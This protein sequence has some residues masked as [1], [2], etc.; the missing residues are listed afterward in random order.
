M[1][2]NGELTD[3]LCDSENRGLTL[4]RLILGQSIIG[5][6]GFEGP[7]TFPRGGNN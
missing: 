4:V 7:C 2:S 1:I 6:K 5:L 3:S